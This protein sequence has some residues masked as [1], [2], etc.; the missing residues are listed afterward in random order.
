MT[1]VGIRGVYII[2]RIFYVPPSRNVLPVNIN[3]SMMT[4]DSTSQGDEGVANVSV[5]W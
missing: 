3:D 4:K 5:T 1:A 2:M